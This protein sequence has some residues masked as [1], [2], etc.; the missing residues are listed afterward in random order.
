MNNHSEINFEIS[1]FENLYT[2]EEI[3]ENINFIEESINNKVK[4][5]STNDFSNG[6]IFNTIMPN[7]IYNRIKN[8]IP[9]IYIDRN[10]IKWEFVNCVN[11]I[12]F[13]KYKPGQLFDI[14]TDTG[15]E[16]DIE[17][18]HYSKFTLLTYLNDNY[19]NGE[20]IFYNDNFEETCRIIPKKNKTLIFDI[21]LFHKGNYVENDCKYW[22]GTELICKKLS[23]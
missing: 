8:L 15:H 13:A 7:K 5:F 23:P 21:N 9:K 14:H 11:Y 16:Y 2:D 4:I 19:K 6:K 18:N 12:F 20:T 3:K 17:N 1:T 10:N 22:I